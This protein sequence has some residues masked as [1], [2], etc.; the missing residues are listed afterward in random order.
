MAEQLKIIIWLIIM[1]I[2]N[3]LEIQSIRIEHKH[4][5]K[6]IFTTIQIACFYLSILVL[7][8]SERDLSQYLRRANSRTSI[9]LCSC[10]TAS[11]V[12]NGVVEQIMHL[13]SHRH[14]IPTGF[15]HVT[16]RL[17]YR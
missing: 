8:S 2:T 11:F 16:V 5:R 15:R 6:L 13:M 10:F 9:R 4:T 7:I 17:R 12:R 1:Q 3:V 14:L